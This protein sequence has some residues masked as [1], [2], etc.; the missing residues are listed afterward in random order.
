[1]T[2][3]II[4]H[5]V[6]WIGISGYPGLVVLMAL[7]SM[8]APLPSEAVMPFAGFLIFEGT[9]TF[10]GVILFSTIGSIVGSLI[11]YYAGLYGGRPFVSHFGRYL[12]LDVHD[13]EYTEKFFDKYGD[14]TIFFSRFIPVV[15]HLIS[16]PAGV[17]EMRLS[18]FV[19]YTTIGAGLWNSFLAYTG[20]RLRSHWETIRH[21]GQTIDILVLILLFAGMGYFIYRHL[22]RL[23]REK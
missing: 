21:Y 13:L 17:G 1:M 2:E 19:V 5:V 11:S 4:N 18:K 23:N 22:R 10:Y 16:I 12:L 6:K 9:L 14:K 7:E 3:L 20:F 8:V 15:R